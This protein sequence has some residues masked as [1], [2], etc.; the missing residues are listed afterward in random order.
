MN[1][2]SSAALEAKTGDTKRQ[3]LT[4][5]EDI[6]QSGASPFA[7]AAQELRSAEV[8]LE[9]WAKAMV[10]GNG[11]EGVTQA[12]YIRLRVANLEAQAEAE[13]VE[14]RKRTEEL[15]RQKL[16]A[17]ALR[18]AK[19]DAFATQQGVTADEAVEMLNHGIRRENGQFVLYLGEGR[20][21]HSYDQLHYAIQYSEVWHR[22]H[23]IIPPNHGHA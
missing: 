4:A 14:S 16:E 21:R 22:R 10:E 2:K 17:E 8:D 9:T 3:A 12:T 6:S 20:F 5:P 19:V 1:V 13:A 15:T 23:N 11:A 7:V 18:I